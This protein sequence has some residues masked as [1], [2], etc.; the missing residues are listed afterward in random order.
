MKWDTAH[1]DDLEKAGREYIE[2]P[3]RRRA[4]SSRSASEAGDDVF[5]EDEDVIIVSD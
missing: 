4:T 5:S 2:P 3:S 1:W